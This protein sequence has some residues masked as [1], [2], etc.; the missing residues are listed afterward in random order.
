MAGVGI[1]LCIIHN[2]E[3][4][5]ERTVKMRNATNFENLLADT[6]KWDENSQQIVQRGSHVTVVYL[7]EVNGHRSWDEEKTD[8]VHFHEKI[9]T[10][11][12]MFHTREMK[13]RFKD[14]FGT[15]SKITP[16]LLETVYQQLT[17]DESAHSNPVV[18]GRIRLIFLGEAGLV[19]D[20][21]TLNP[22]RPS[23]SFD[24]FFEK[25]GAVINEVTAADDRRHGKA[26]VAP[27]VSLQ[28]FINQTKERCSDDTKIPSKALVRLQFTHRN[29]YSHAALCFTSRFDVQYKIQRRQLRAA[30]PDQHYAAAQLKYLK[31]FTVQHRDCS[32]L[33]FTDDKAKIA[34]GEPG[35]L[36]ST[37][38]R[39]RK[40]LVPTSSILSAEDHDVHHKGSLTPSVY[41]DCSVP[42]NAKSSFF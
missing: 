1:P 27:W 33:I 35:H 37:G 5:S 3:K 31:H 21:R 16:A 11:F 12:P 39:G 29:P 42:E 24:D 34:F 9:R 7:C 40:S 13:R 4:K 20:M 19:P 17:L 15:I 28:D 14:Q 25:M 41:L 10:T 18:A 26:H 6:W 36:L 38:V 2:C 23:G 30:H 32:A 8:A 22:G